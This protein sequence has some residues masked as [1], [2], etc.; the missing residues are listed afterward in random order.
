MASRPHFRALALDLEPMALA[1]KVQ[2]LGLA[3]RL[4]LVSSSMPEELP[5]IYDHLC[6][7]YYDPSSKKSKLEG[8]HDPDPMPHR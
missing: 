3:L 2:A 4:V 1:S 5:A 8:E 6:G 7:I